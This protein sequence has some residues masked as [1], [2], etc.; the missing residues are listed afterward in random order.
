MKYSPIFLL[1]VVCL[2]FAASPSPAASE[3][4]V[5][6]SGQNSTQ[7]TQWIDDME[8]G[9][10]PTMVDEVQETL[11]QKILGS[12]AWVD[13]FFSDSR[14]E[15]DV[16]KTRLKLKGSFKVQEYKDP[17]A[18]INLDLRLRLPVFE[19]RF[20]LII[21]GDP[22]DE[23]DL[24]DSAEGDARNKFQG[25]DKKNLT[26]ALRYYFLDSEMHNVSLDGGARWRD[27][28]VA[29]FGQT[30]YRFYYDFDPWAIR[31][32]ERVRLYSDTGP[33]SATTLDFER[34]LT[35]DLF[36]RTSGEVEWFNQD[37]G[38]YYNFK[39]ILYQVL[40]KKQS[41][42]Y[43]WENYF[44]TSPC[45]RLDMIRFK[46]KYRR[47]IWRKWLFAEVEPELAFPDEH[48]FKPV[49]G[50]VFRLE[51]NLGFHSKTK[52]QNN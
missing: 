7:E 15:N 52:G 50:V 43:K 14:Y 23:D 47:Q 45:N 25:T 29:V 26:A 6:E 16:N 19:K 27:N 48:D 44:Q 39:G 10:D 38:V 37:D 18:D 5:S 9:D 11:S 24:N 35:R 31:L 13:S 17:K 12:A 28:G 49:P 46:V 32:Q 51:V 33:E 40:D 2:L 1:A 22:D 21:S 34:P 3:D 8:P 4:P 30:R 36:F 41:L 42:E 20:Q